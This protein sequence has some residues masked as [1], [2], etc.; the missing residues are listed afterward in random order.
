MDSYICKNF[1]EY[2]CN[3]ISPRSYF[4]NEHLNKHW[5][6]PESNEFQILKNTN[7]VSILLKY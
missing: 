1:P 3:Y 6:E 4:C 2:V 7:L 5:S